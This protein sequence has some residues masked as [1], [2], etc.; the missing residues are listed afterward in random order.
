[1]TRTDIAAK[2][3]AALLAAFLLLAGAV[4]VQAETVIGSG[5]RNNAEDS[6]LSVTA[7]DPAADLSNLNPGDGKTSRLRLKNTGSYL[8]TVYMKVQIESEIS[9]AGGALADRMTLTVSDGGSFSQD[10]T[11]RTAAAAGS[12]P[13]GTLMPGAAETL[14]FSVSLPGLLTDNRYQGASMN[15]EWVFTAVYS[16]VSSTPS[17]HGGG[18][19]GGGGYAA[20]AVS[21]GAVAGSEPPPAGTASRTPESPPS[22][23]APGSS[24]PDQAAAASPATGERSITPFRVFIACAAVFGA[25][26]VFLIAARKIRRE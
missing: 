3:A 2:G 24:R 13:V 20:A 25:G 16:G 4:P 6:G 23:S 1:M 12:V 7:P 26:A 22:E 11:F 14:S 21:S 8:L 17:H 15:V 19:G 18:G 10:E 5:F 9:P